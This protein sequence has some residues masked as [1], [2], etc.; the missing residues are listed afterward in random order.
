MNDTT[1]LAK[2]AVDIRGVRHRYRTTVAVDDVSLTIA[3]GST[4]ALIGPDGVGKSTLLAIVAGVKRIQEGTVSALSANLSNREQRERVQPRI[5]Y[6]PQGL[7]KN[8]YPAMTVSE[9]IEFFG[10]LFGQGRAERDERIEKLLG[11]IGL[12][13]FAAR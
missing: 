5:A 4:M 1:V 13:Q 2:A 9:N 12:A 6:M 11:A 3:P 8:L 10:R 7:G